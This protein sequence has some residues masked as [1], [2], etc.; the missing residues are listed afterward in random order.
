MQSLIEAIGRELLPSLSVPVGETIALSCQSGEEGWIVQQSLAAAL[1]RAGMKVYV[2]R[3]SVPAPNLVVEVRSVALGVGY[4]DLSRDQVM[5]TRRI[6][7]T[8]SAAFV[9]LATDARTGKVLFSGTPARQLAD[10]VS[11]DDVP[12]LESPTV[13]STHADLPS[14]SFLD[15]MVEPFVILGATGIAVYLLFHVRS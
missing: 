12:A 9:C 15:R 14:G 13:R 6:T 1:T 4:T 5:G 2:G 3:D 11:A 7:R 8:V 10:T